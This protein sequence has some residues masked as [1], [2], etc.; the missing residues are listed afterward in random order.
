MNTETIANS[1][2]TLAELDVDIARA[3]AQIGA[4]ASRHRP[5]GFTAAAGSDYGH[6]VGIRAGQSGG[7]H[8]VW[9]A[10]SAHPAG[11]IKFRE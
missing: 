3:Y 1:M 11:I 6:C 4:P 10:E 2:A 8:L 5:P 7:R 9:L